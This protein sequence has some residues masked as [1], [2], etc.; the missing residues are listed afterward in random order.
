MPIIE[1]VLEIGPYEELPSNTFPGFVERLTTWLPTLQKHGCS[2]GREG[3][4]VS[5]L[6]SGTYLPH[7]AEH[8]TLA[9]QEHMGFDVSFGRARTTDQPGVH[10]VVFAY[11]E[12]EPARAA[13]DLSLK[14]VLAAMHDAPLDL[15][16]ELDKLCGV[17]DEYRL[18]PS[19]AAIVD[20]AR[21]RS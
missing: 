9:L 3:G 10:K 17:A 8:V 13:F 21:R 12:E 11:R 1:A 15:E 7:I 16:G 4:F 6:R 2:T 5:R 19:T 18:G 14:V 20:A